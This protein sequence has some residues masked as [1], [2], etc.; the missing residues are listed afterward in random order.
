MDGCN[1]KLETKWDCRKTI[2][3]WK[4]YVTRYTPLLKWLVDVMWYKSLLIGYAY[5]WSNYCLHFWF[6]EVTVCHLL[7]QMSMPLKQWIVLHMKI[8]TTTKL[9][10]RIILTNAYYS[11][12]KIISKRILMISQ[13][14]SLISLVFSDFECPPF[15]ILYQCMY[16]TLVY[17]CAK[18]MSDLTMHNNY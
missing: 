6:T 18:W 12:L 16:C 17:R 3:K 15:H 7:Q 13:L 2:T 1:V 4:E 14:M 10:V 8:V 9:H 5:C 11:I